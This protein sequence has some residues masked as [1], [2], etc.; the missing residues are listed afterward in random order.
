MPLDTPQDRAFEN[1]AYIPDAGAYRGRWAELA[2]AFRDRIVG[3][4]DVPYGEDPRER[5]DLF[6]PE[7]PRG[8]AVF[9][10]GGYWMALDK[11]YWSHLSAGP[12]AHGFAVAVPS[13]PLCPQV[14]IGAIV[15][16][17]GA[18]I[19]HAGQRIDG[20]IRLTGHSAGGHLAARMACTDAPVSSPVRERIDKVVPISALSDLRPILATKM[21][22]TLCL[23]LV[24]ARQESPVLGEPADIDIVAWVG[25]GER[26]ELRRQTCL[27]ALIWEGLARSVRHVEAPDRHHFDVIGDLAD[28]ASA[29]TEA[30]VG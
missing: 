29:L 9:I 5:Y 22:E 1:G 13:Y 25:D 11:S 26:P 27:L 19:S 2:Q 21:N 17:I 3:E 15:R 16:S 12:M 4:L 30:L 8:L 24:E 6:S 20:P 7:K 10:H 23:D 14:R 18:A 28:P